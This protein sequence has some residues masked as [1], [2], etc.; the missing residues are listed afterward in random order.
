MGKKER[1]GESKVEG[2][3]RGGGMGMGEEEERRRW[4]Y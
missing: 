1:Y 2:G 3:S 4:R